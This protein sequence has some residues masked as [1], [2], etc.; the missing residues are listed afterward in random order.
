MTQVKA[1]QIDIKGIVQ[2]VG[3]RPFVYNLASRH[4][5]TGWVR[6]TTGGVEIEVIGPPKALDQFLEGLANEAPPLSQIDSIEHKL[7]SAEN[8]GSFQILNSN[9][10]SA[11]ILPISPDVSVCSDCL[12]ELFSP[13]DFRYR[14]PFI[15]CTNCGPRFTIIRDIP[16]DRPKTTMASFTFCQ[17]CQSEYEDPLDRR[18][19]AQPVA[20]PECGPKIWLESARKPGERISEGDSALI[21]SQSLLKEGKILALKGLG[22]FH[23]AC[24]AEDEKVVQRLRER[25]DRP[26]K[27][28]AVMMPNLDV[29]AEHCNISE[30]EK[31]LLSSPQHPI[32]LLAKKE[33]SNLPE[34]LAPGQNSLGVML[35]YTP[36][37]YLLFSSKADYPDSPYSVLV[38][39]SANFMGNPIITDNQEVRLDLKSIADYF[40]FHDRD[41]HVHCDDSVVRI[42]NNLG[43]NASGLYPIRRSRGYA[44]QPLR[45]PLKGG[46]VLGVGAELKNTFCLTRED[47][48]FL[49]QHIGDLKNYETLESFEEGISHFEGLFRINPELI[50]HDGH[51]DYL[52]TRYALDRSEKNN[53]PA[54]SVQHHHAHIAACLADNDYQSKEPVIGI[55]FDGIG[56]GDDGAI[57]GGEFLIADYQKYSRGGQLKYFPLPGGD[58][59]IRQPWR[60]ALAILHHY[61]IDWDEDLPPSIFGSTRFHQHL[62]PEVPLIDSLRNQLQ[63]ETNTPPTSSMGRLFDAVSSMIGIRH[64][65]SYEGQAAIEL[66][67]LADKDE[68]GSYPFDLCDDNVIDFKQLIQ[69]IIRDYREKVSYPIIASRFHNSVA[70]MVLQVCLNLKNEHQLTRVALSGGVW[71]NM[72]LLQKA[73]QSLQKSGFEVLLHQKTPPNDGSIA[74]GQA[75]IGQRILQV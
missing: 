5:L 33:D 12:A 69:S 18:F 44:P 54:Y 22:G 61:D 50:V 56:Y 68:A 57:W 15:N 66:E 67:A 72:T 34:G 58:L 55:A 23:L 47:Y 60:T 75:V 45:L 62:L 14:Y 8:H 73:V 37:H 65:I 74:F 24:N 53:L 39:T 27:P 20:C 64:I 13:Q 26:A 28:L 31:N 30:S 9:D 29:V 63:K 16:Y 10:T 3:F 38:M 42:Q 59:A 43:V 17:T 6:N 4:K 41:I 52:S 36:L 46:Q 49:S 19:H 70:E 21:Q 40:L 32:L 35:P 48:A 7:T 1:Y 25:K 71:Q 2:G 51:P 11:G